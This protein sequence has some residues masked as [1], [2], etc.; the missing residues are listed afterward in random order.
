M[1]NYLTEV[2]TFILIDILSKFLNIIIINAIRTPKI[3]EMLNTKFVHRT[4]TKFTQNHL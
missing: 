3:M 1:R 4:L 2:N